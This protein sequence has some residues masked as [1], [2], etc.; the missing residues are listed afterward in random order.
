MS[1]LSRSRVVIGQTLVESVIFDYDKPI[2][3]CFN[4]AGKLLTDRQVAN[5]HH[6]WSFEFLASQRINAVSI[7]TIGH[8][9]WFLCEQLEQ[10]LLELNTTLKVF[11]ERLGYGASM[12]AYGISRY[13][14]LLDINRAL[15]FSPLLPPQSDQSETFD[16]L[17]DVGFTLVFDPFNAEDKDVAVR[18]PKST[19]YLHFY[20]VGHQVIESTAKI[21]LLKPLLLS[22]YGNQNM[23]V[24]FYKQQTK[25]RQLLRYYSYLDRNPTGKNTLRRRFVIKKHKLV[26]I[27]KHSDQIVEKVLTKLRKSLKKKLRKLNR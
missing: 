13:A 24:E 17:T 9:H 8:N 12:G 11:P 18:Y 3:V 20:A 15:L 22:F 6:A 10:Y 1:E 7:N 2:I 26:Y 25:K 19:H 23:T 16:H 4:P 14:N 27:V 5:G 21:G